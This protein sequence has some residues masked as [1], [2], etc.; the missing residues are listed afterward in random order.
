M[1]KEMLF[2]RHLSPAHITRVTS[3][4]RACTTITIAQT[5]ANHLAVH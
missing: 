2:M 1:Q 3:D 4:Q 5:R